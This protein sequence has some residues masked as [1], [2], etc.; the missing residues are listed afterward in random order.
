M[1]NAQ[2]WAHLSAQSLFFE[3]FFSC[4]I[5]EDLTIRYRRPATGTAWSS[6]AR[7]TFV[8]EQISHAHQF[9]SIISQSFP[10]VRRID[11]RRLGHLS[12]PSEPNYFWPRPYFPN[13]FNCIFLCH[14]PIQLQHFSTYP[15]L[16]SSDRQS[17]DKKTKGLRL[18]RKEEKK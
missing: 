15:F 1:R 10:I 9:H 12:L 13:V 6:A 11:C 14:S 4:K 5:E 18:G 3:I 8:M 7:G 2:Q 16:S 17:E